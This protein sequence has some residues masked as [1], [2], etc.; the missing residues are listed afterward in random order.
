M[1]VGYVRVSTI[2][3]SAERQEKDLSEN[4]GVERIFLDKLSG[5]D[6]NRPQL[7]EMLD[8]VRSGDTVIVSDFSRLA[9]SVQ[10]LLSIIE[11]LNAKGVAVISRKE[12][13]DTTTPQ[14]KLMLTV[15]AGIAEFE[16]TIMLQR[17]RE[18]IAIA[19]EYGKYK[20]RAK[21]EKPENWTELQEA[22][23]VRRLRITDLVKEC[24]V[25]RP[26]IYKW[27][28]EPDEDKLTH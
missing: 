20:G 22:Y 14:G 25:S 13:L 10:D 7:K 27:L 6:T 28:K 15:F 23:Q 5:K 18:G 16:R 3:Q 4:A 24:Q 12:N 21:A 1:K 26:T 2:E 8:F 19:K 17:Q 9:R 11:T